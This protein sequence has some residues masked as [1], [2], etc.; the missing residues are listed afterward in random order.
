MLSGLPARAAICRP[1]RR[2]R[3]CEPTGTPSLGYTRS[4]SN[5]RAFKPACARRSHRPTDDSYGFTSSDIDRGSRQKWLIRVGPRR[6]CSNTS[7]IHT[8]LVQ[9]CCGDSERSDGCVPTTQRRWSN[10]GG[11]L[12]RMARPQVASSR[13][14]RAASGATPGSVIKRRYGDSEAPGC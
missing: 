2:R 13:V 12:R 9:S 14:P 7:W 6:P 1:D 5:P 4:M 3:L 11:D 8:D 10:N